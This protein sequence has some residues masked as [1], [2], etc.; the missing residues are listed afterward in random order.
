M[1][2]FFTSLRT[3]CKIIDYVFPEMS[4]YFPVESGDK[5]RSPTW[6]TDLYTGP[7]LFFLVVTWFKKRSLLSTPG[8]RV[9]PTPSHP[10]R[11]ENVECRPPRDRGLTGSLVR[12]R[13][14]LLSPSGQSSMF[15]QGPVS[16]VVSPLGRRSR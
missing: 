14:S 3:Y 7:H 15:R 13:G 6:F 5:V 10:R 2:P 8:A 16:N 12:P 9:R 4:P 11:R 1:R